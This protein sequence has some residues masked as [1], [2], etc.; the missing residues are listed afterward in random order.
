MLILTNTPESN[1][2]QNKPHRGVPLP[3]G[4]AECAR[5]GGGRAHPGALRAPGKSHISS[6]LR[7]DGRSVFG[8]ASPPPPESRH[9]NRRARA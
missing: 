4:G 1:A 9:P 7:G 2:C 8:Q 5:L 6:R 3:E